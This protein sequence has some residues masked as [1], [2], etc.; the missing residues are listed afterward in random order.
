MLAMESNVKLKRTNYSVDGGTILKQEIQDSVK[1][2]KAA[3]NG[4]SI[5]DISPTHNSSFYIP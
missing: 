4:M 5:N 1:R 2:M 3:K